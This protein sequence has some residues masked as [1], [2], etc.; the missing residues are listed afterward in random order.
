MCRDGSARPKRRAAGVPRRQGAK[1][2]PRRE[3]REE[4][5]G[6]PPREPTGTAMPR[7]PGGAEMTEGPGRAPAPAA[8]ARGR[9]HRPSAGMGGEGGGLEPRDPGAGSDGS[10]T[11]VTFQRL[12]DRLR[13]LGA[14]AAAT[15]QPERA[16]REEG[17]EAEGGAAP[18]AARGRPPHTERARAGS[19]A[20]GGA[21]LGSEPLSPG[22][23][24]QGAA[25]R[26]RRRSR[27]ARWSF[28]MAP[29]KA[30][31]ASRQPALR[32]GSG[33]PRDTPQGR[34]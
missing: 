8:A 4:G 31:T 16:W 23:A 25:G 15:R 21:E 29:G 18:P 17:G 26:E 11:A 13:H 2:G 9:S 7:Q 10:G 27:S 28:S 5:S 20:R 24:R 12:E 1:G 14:G 3:R 22:G 34:P 30:P 6:G 33:A 32:R 19:G